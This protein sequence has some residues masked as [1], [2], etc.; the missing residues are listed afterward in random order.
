MQVVR[1]CIIRLHSPELRMSTLLSYPRA[2][3]ALAF[4]ALV[5]V[6]CG[7]NSAGV[8]GNIGKRDAGVDAG[9]E[10]PDA[11]GFRV[12]DPT[13]TEICD[14][15]D[16]NCDGRIDEGF[17]LDHDGVTTCA[18]I[19]DCA[20][21]DP[22]VF[23]GA[24]E[25][26]N[27]KD[28]DCD[29]RIDY[30][31]PGVD[32]D[33][34]GTP[35]PDDC[36]DDNP[37]VSPNAVEVPLLP[38]GGTEG[39][40]NDCDGVIDDVPD[41]ETTG[42]AGDRAFANAMGLCA[43]TGLVSATFTHGPAAARTIRSKLGS[44]ILPRDGTKMVHL[45]TGEAKDANDSNWA[46]PQTGKEFNTKDPHPLWAPPRCANMGQPPA[47]DMTELTLTL[48]VPVN[49]KS[50]SYQL[51]FLSAEFPEWVCTQYNDRFI[52]ILKSEALDASKLPGGAGPNCVGGSSANGC[53]ISFDSQ[54]Q[55]VTINNGLFT[56]CQNYAPKNT[57]CAPNS[58]GQLAQTGYD[59]PD[60]VR[61]LVGGAT[62]WL[63][64]RAPVKPGET[65]TLRF[66][67]LDEGDA[68]YDSAVLLDNF[69]W[70]LQAVDAPSTVPIN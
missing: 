43:K 36:D 45:S 65:V 26:A 10:V 7:P 15:V 48:K 70:E 16:N 53:N 13:W 54:G 18:P 24:T 57:Q 32:Y 20:D 6:G 55:P 4:A 3:A 11:G 25:V 64:T 9:G 27:G 50:L 44:Q 8:G 56:V 12:C 58:W 51:Y 33:H 49:A 19:P 2:V 21:D 30:G 34:D 41:C 29:G 66:I 60:G 22:T 17:D 37:L 67:I 46:G 35:F 59:E 14:G 23:P 52:A 1:L 62:G 5:A 31:V 47:E 38:D 68:K 40:D 63:T 69:K 61:G 39:V 28:D 42:E